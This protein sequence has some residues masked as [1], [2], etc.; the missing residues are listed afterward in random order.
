ME[1]EHELSD[2]RHQEYRMRIGSDFESERCPTGVD[3]RE[4]I[5]ERWSMPV[6]LDFRLDVEE[7]LSKLYVQAALV[8]ALVDQYSRA[9]ITKWRG[10]QVNSIVEKLEVSRTTDQ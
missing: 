8:R 9:A 7:S 3:E 6:S 2:G 4:V 10:F 1:G 5:D